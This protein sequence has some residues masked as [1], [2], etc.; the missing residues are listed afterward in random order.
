MRENDGPQEFMQNMDRQLAV[1]QTKLDYL[2]EAD[3]QDKTFGKDLSIRIGI[4]ES[5]RTW[6]TGAIA[7]TFF[8]SS[9]LLYA[10]RVQ[11]DSLIQTRLRDIDYVEELCADVRIRRPSVE[12]YPKVCKL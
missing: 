8:F 7:A 10:L 11:V 1:L 12:A 6:L 2:I 5:H 4:L 9:A 3:K